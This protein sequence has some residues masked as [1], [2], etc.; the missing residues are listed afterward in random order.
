[1]KME[2]FQPWTTN[3]CH[4][5]IDCNPFFGGK[6][7]KNLKLEILSPSMKCVFWTIKNT[8]FF[9]EKVFQKQ[10]KFLSLLSKKEFIYFFAKF[11]NM[12]KMDKRIQ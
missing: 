4:L 7:M 10:Q 8:F 9:L 6:E 12:I 5:F 11:S 3:I 1:M 2:K